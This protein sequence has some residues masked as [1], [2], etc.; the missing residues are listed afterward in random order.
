MMAWRSD[1]GVSGMIDPDIGHML[2]ELYVTEGPRGAYHEHLQLY[3]HVVL[4]TIISI[5]GINVSEHL[6]NYFLSKDRVFVLW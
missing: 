6:N 1:A 5:N 2:L 3:Y 4:V